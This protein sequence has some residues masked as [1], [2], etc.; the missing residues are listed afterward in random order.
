MRDDPEVPDDIHPLF[1]GAPATTEVR[2]PRKRIVRQTREAIETYGMARPGDKLM[3]CLSGGKDSYALLDILL[4]LREQAP[5]HFDI[6]AVNLDQKQ[7]GLPE[8]VL[9]DY[10]ARPATSRST[11]R[12]RTPTPSSS[13]SPR[14]ERSTAPSALV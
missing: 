13:A 3:V 1:H 6:V 9:P 11:S 5:I 8:H 7:P 12:S 4:A 2:K 10:L 14:P